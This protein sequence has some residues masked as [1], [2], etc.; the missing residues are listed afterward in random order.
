MEME[1]KR[2]SCRSQRVAKGSGGRVDVEGDHGQMLLDFLPGFRVLGLRLAS[3]RFQKIGETG[4]AGTGVRIAGAWREHE[5]TGG[6]DSIKIDQSINRVKF[7]T[8]ISQQVGLAS[9][10]GGVKSNLSKFELGA[11]VIRGTWA[12]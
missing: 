5:V 8:G 3:Y 2:K 10:V 1:G 7:A 6:N 4:E 12:A 9:G 11:Y